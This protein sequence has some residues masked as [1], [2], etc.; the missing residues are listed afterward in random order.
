MVNGT[1]SYCLYTVNFGISE[2]SEF[3]TKASHCN[4]FSLP[5]ASVLL[6]S[7]SLLMGHQQTGQKALTHSPNP[8]IFTTFLNAL[9]QCTFAGADLLDTLQARVHA[10]QQ[11]KA[12]VQHCCKQAKFV[13]GIFGTRED[14]LLSV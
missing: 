8:S 7:L 10:A 6:A 5:L 11:T 14:P 13:A 12:K 1:F 2:F 9:V 4:M 3:Q